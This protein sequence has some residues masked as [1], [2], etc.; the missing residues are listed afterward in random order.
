MLAN[1]RWP[2]LM[3]VMALVIGALMLFGIAMLIYYLLQPDAVVTPWRILGAV[4]GV[5][6][7]ITFVAVAIT[8]G[9]L[10]ESQDTSDLRRK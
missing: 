7:G 8:G 2:P 6:F 4:A 10:Q 3:R 1:K 5:L 9:P